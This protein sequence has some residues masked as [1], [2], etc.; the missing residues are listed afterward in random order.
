MTARLVGHQKGLV[1]MHAARSL[2]KYRKRAQKRPGE[3]NRG[4]NWT[5]RDYQLLFAGIMAGWRTGG[6]TKIMGRGGKG[7]VIGKIKRMREMG[8]FICVVGTGLEAI[9]V[10]L[11][12]DDVKQQALIALNIDCASGEP[13]FTKP[14]V[15]AMVHHVDIDE[16]RAWNGP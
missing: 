11:N 12:D 8:P 6:I 5:D 14:D 9:A 1:S 7:V 10:G 2:R 4:P 16:L 15:A 13:L 3:A